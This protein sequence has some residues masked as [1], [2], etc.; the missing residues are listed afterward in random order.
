MIDSLLAVLINK[1]Y[2]LSSVRKFNYIFPRPNAG[3]LVYTIITHESMNGRAHQ[4]TLSVSYDF[5]WFPM[6][7]AVF[8]NISMD[9][10]TITLNPGPDYMHVLPRVFT[11]HSSSECDR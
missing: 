9:K 7:F 5:L 6:H 11:G 2:I 4:I 10:K 8:V 3:S 1:I